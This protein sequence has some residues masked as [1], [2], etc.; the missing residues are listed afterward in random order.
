MV[1]KP[2]NQHYLHKLERWPGKSGPS[3]D[4]QIS[5]Q[6]T[7]QRFSSFS[8]SHKDKRTSKSINAGNTDRSIASSNTSVF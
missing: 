6:L 5:R 8:L 4:G 2:M 1:E 7:A 3:Q